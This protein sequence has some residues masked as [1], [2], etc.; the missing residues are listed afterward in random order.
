MNADLLNKL[1]RIHQSDAI[2]LCTICRAPFWIFPKKNPPY[3]PFMV[4][5]LDQ[6]VGLILNQKVLDERPSSDVVLNVLFKSMQGTL[7]TLGHSRRPTSI[8]IN[9]ANLTQALAPQLAKLDIRCSYRNNMPEMRP[10]LLEMEK[11]VNKREPIPGLLSIPGVSVPLVAEL[12]ASAAN[13]YTLQP[14]HW[15]ENWLPIEVRCPPEGQARYALILG[16]GGETFGISLYESLADLDVLF[17]R[18]DPDRPP[19]RPLN[20]LS[21]VLEEETAMAIEDLDAIEQYGWPVAGPHAYPLVLKATS[22][23]DWGQLP[24]ATELTWLVAALRAIPEFLTRH[25]HADR[26]VPQ[27]SQTI[28]LLSG[29]YGNQSI[30]MRFPAQ[31][32]PPTASALSKTKNVQESVVQPED[33]LEEYIEDWH[34]DERSH[35]FA[36]QMG[37]FLFQF[38]D[39]LESTGLSRATMHKHET[40]CWCIGWLECGYGYHD[41]FIPSIF[42][43]GPSFLIEFKRKVSDSKYALDSYQATWRKLEKYIASLGYKEE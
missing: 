41:T 38:L 23:D 6:K 39:Y 31:A 13:Y 43:D 2:W 4:L 10:I 16:I 35:E 25:L 26:G 30:F 1:H 7:L 29:V 28:S 22:G 19:S 42:L 40:N 11:N 18:P 17:D 21:V 14:W 12:F 33:D 36:R 32:T 15:M 8:L 5:V 3:R 37:R 20:W 27:P 9:D 34:Y 24:N